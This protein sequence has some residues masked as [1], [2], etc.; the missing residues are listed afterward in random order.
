MVTSGSC[1]ELRAWNGEGASGGFSWAASD[2][3]HDKIA[4]AVETFVYSPNG[5]AI[6][7]GSALIEIHR[8]L[9]LR[10]IARYSLPVIY[11]DRF[12]VA[13]RT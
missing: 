3:G 2:T 12:I 6:V 8:D 4:S 5:G 9:I 10:L 1:A 13:K 7:T 11:P